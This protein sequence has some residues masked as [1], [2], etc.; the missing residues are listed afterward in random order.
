VVGVALGVA[1][2]GPQVVALA[3]APFVV[4]QPAL[5]AGL[6]IVL[7]L[8]ARIL[9]ERVGT[10][11]LSGV[12]GI[13]GG[14]AL[15]SWGAPPHTE[16]HR[17]GAAVIGVMGA[18]AAGG[19]VPFLLRG[20]WLDTALLTIVASGC[21]FAAGN[22]ATKLFSDDV[23]AGHYPNAAAWAVIGLLMGVAATVTGMTAFQRR[24]ATV[25]VPVST[26]VQTFLPI[27]LEPFFLR[28]RWASADFYGVP[29][30]LGLLVA[31]IGT[32]LITR[33]RAVS[34]LVASAGGPQRR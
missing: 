16:T 26:S 9:N 2:I 11:E 27:V 3:H 33:S 21:G 19:L 30:A 14:V 7:L 18:L 5:A 25:V 29:I 8:G 13:I 1:G 4:V 22:V 15:V 6:L 10:R 20:T 32:I 28:E 17:G 24:A 34:D 23:N 31:L 12:I